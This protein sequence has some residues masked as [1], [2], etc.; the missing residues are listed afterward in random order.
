VRR[1]GKTILC[2]GLPNAEYFDCELPTVRRLMEKPESFLEDLRGKR[3][4]LDEVHRLSDP[5]ELLKIAADHYPDI[6]V[7]ATGSSTLQAS[8]HFR[9]TLTGRKESLWL[10]PMVEAD[11][12][13]FGRGDLKHRLLHGGLPPFYLSSGDDERDR[14]EWLASFWA[15]D[16]MELFR[17]ERRAA[18]LRLLELLM[19]NSGGIFEASAYSAPCEISRQT[20]SNYLAVLEEAWAVHVIRPFSG[21]KS[22]EI[23]AAPRVYA[24][25]TGFVCHAR[26]W[27]ELRPDDLGILW[28]HYVLNEMQGVSQKRDFHY[29]RDKAGH[30]VDFILIERGG[31]PTAVECKWSADAF[32]PGGLRAFR[33]RHPD[34]LNYC[35]SADVD[36][37]FRRTFKPGLEV[38]F[39]GL[40][41]LL[42][43]MGFEPETRSAA[44]TGKGY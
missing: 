10:S 24:F 6:K 11:R 34:G 37:S 36:R 42:K 41:G 40:H 39:V 18:F 25:D 14:Q 4:V 20:V 21:R 32:E 44:R 38:S 9:D 16:V 31:K 12:R 43:A 22:S 33:N 27:H 2:Q 15:R 23:V 35:V 3:I 8:S 30:E 1:V 5:S 13:D 7:I 26:G 19:V 29:W 28:E 17:L